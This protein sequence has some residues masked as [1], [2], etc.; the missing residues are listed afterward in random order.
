MFCLANH[1]G[2]TCMTMHVQEVNK[3]GVTAPT[4]LSVYSGAFGPRDTSLDAAF[5]VVKFF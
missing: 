4:C 3:Y 5:E 2:I 1:N